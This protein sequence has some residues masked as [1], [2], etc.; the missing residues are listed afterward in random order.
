[1]HLSWLKAAE[2][3]IGKDWI[4]VTG[5]RTLVT[6][7]KWLQDPICTRADR[8]VDLQYVTFFQ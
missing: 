6:K 5:G 2:T 1:M 7:E 3:E 8:T 4:A